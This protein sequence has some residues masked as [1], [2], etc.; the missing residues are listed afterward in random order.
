[1]PSDETEEEILVG[2]KSRVA[3]HGQPC[4]IILADTFDLA[5][6]AATKVDVTYIEMKSIAF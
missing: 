1:M 5:N 6:F 3:F 2:T 4:G